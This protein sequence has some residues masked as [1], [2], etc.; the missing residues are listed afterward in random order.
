MKIIEVIKRMLLEKHCIVCSEPIS[1]DKKEPFC[2]NCIEEWDSFIKAKCKKC[3]RENTLCTCLPSKV[4]KINH[5]LVSWCY[6]YNGDENGEINKLFTYL[7][8]VYDREVIDFCTDRMKASVLSMCKARGI[9][10]KDFLVTYITRSKH[11]VNK[12]GF[13]QS[14]KLAKSLAKKLG[15]NVVK[16]FNNVGKIEQ[17]GLNKKERAKNAFETYEFIE[18]SLGDNKQLF[19]V[20]DI[21]TTGASMLAC[22]IHLFKNGATTVIPV[23]FAKDNL[24]YKG[25]IKNVKRNTKYHIARAI[26]GFVRNGTQR[27][28]SNC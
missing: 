17:K 6:F 20:D 2:D 22:S 12:Y 26:K 21:L 27:Q 7:K 5:S 13:D 3:G 16:A 11:N 28:N 19:L 4:R 9:D 10:Y 15:I 1:Y 14:E 25:D 23:V 18:G 8:K 24:K